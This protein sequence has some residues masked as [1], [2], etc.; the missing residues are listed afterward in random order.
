MNFDLTGKLESFV[1]C[2]DSTFL[3]NSSRW[4]AAIESVVDKTYFWGVG[5]CSL[6]KFRGEGRIQ[7]MAF[8]WRLLEWLSF[9]RV[10]ESF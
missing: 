5:R 8:R 10:P 4:G 9:P 6:L 1:E 2:G 3:A 7:E